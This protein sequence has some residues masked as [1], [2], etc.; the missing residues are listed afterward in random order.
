MIEEGLRVP[1][2]RDTYESIADAVANGRIRSIIKSGEVIGFFT[3]KEVYKNDKLFVFIENMC[4]KRQ[5]RSATNLLFLR[6]FFRSFYNERYEFV[7]WYSQKKKGY[8][9]CK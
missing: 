2:L 1:N 4:V 8:Y 9:Y 5:F 3:W 7:Y 6:R